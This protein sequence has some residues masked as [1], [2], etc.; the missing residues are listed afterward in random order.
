VS[1][2]G[3]W[4]PRDAETLD[5]WVDKHIRVVPYA[6]P[7]DDHIKYIVGIDCGFDGPH[8]YSRL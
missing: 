8:G 5:D 3:V 7:Y 6:L 1:G 2:S 4:K